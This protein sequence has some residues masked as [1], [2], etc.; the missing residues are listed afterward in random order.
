MAARRMVLLASVLL[1][2]ACSEPPT[3]AVPIT[4]V[5]AVEA[6]DFFSQ[7]EFAHDSLSSTATQRVYRVPGKWLGRRLV[8]RLG[9]TPDGAVSDVQLGMPSGLVRTTRAMMRGSDRG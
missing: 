4:T 1:A 2:A 7:F 5:A 6:T 9:L 3:P 8:L